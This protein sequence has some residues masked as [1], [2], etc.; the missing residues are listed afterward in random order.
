MW[1]VDPDLL[2][3]PKGFRRTADEA[4]RMREIRGS[5]LDS[6]WR[7]TIMNQ[8]AGREGRVRNGDVSSLYQAKNLLREGAGILNRAEA[9]RET[10]K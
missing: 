2:W 6:A 7:E 1:L 9:F 8:S 5:L 3:S 10:G 4:F